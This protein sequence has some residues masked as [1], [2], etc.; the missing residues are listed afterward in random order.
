M[1]G[2]KTMTMNGGFPG[3]IV[4]ERRPDHD[5]IFLEFECLFER[6]QTDIFGKKIEARKP[7]RMEFQ[8]SEKKVD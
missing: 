8:R 1:K 2:F 5:E 4:A 3:K 7:F 6:D